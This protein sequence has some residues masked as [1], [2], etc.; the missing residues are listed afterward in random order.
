MVSCPSHRARDSSHLFRPSIV[1]TFMTA[2]VSGSCRPW[3][4][5]GSPTNVQITL[6]E[7][8]FYIPPTSTLKH[9]PLKWS[10]QNENSWL[11]RLPKSPSREAIPN[12]NYLLTLAGVV[13]V[14]C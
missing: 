10:P 8:S 9:L 6:Q 3:W 2:L 4:L 1:G 14:A 5:A 11:R 13:P 7:P 12:K